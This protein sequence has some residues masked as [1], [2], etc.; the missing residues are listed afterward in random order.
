MNPDVRN[1]IIWIIL[2]I[3]IGGYVYLSMGSISALEYYQVYI[4]EK[5][6]YV[7]NLLVFYIIFNYFSVTKKDQHKYLLY[8]IIG[9]FIFRGIIIIS[10]ISLIERFHWIIYVLGLFLMYTGFK[11]LKSEEE[12]FNTRE[13]WYYKFL[14]KRKI[15]IGLFVIAMIEITDIIFALDSI[16]VSLGISHNMTIICTANFMA[17]LGLRSLYFVLLEFID[18]FPYLKYGISIVLLMIGCKMILSY[19]VE[20]PIELSLLL[21]C[22]TLGISCLPKGGRNA[23]RNNS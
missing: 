3:L 9:A 10:G 20:I 22:A 21:T 17:V 5:M 15:N 4:C 14:S 19:F 8:G 13:C 23:A 12:N 18:K 6:L 11:I 2:S 1:S 7:Y 16:P